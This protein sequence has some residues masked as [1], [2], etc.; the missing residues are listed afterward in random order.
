MDTFGDARGQ[1]TQ[2]GAVLLFAIAIIALSIY[3]ASVIPAQNEAAEFEHSQQVREDLLTVHNAIIAATD[4]G[5]RSVLV[6]LGLRYT[7]RL[8]GVNPGPVS[9]TIRTL[10]GAPWNGSIVID[11]ATATGETGDYWTGTPRRF[12]TSA[13]AYRARYHE[14]EGAG[15]L[16]TENTVFYQQFDDRKLLATGQHLVDGRRIGLVSLTG[17]LQQSGTRAQSISIR[18]LSADET[19]VPVRSSGGPITITVPTRLSA[20]TWR[21]MLDEDGELAADG[22]YVVGVTPG[23]RPETV[24]I[25]LAA[26]ETYLIDSSLVAVGS[27]GHRPTAA[28]LTSDDAPIVPEGGTARIEMT[29]RD[30]YD[31]GI[32]GVTVRVATARS[33]SSV[34]PQ[35]AISGA[36]GT[37]TVTYTAPDEVTGVEATDRVVAS[38]DV[39]PASGVDGTT[40]RNVSIPVIVQSRGSGGSGGSTTETYPTAFDD[41]DGTAEPSEDSALPP[42]DPVGDLANFARLATDGESATLSEAATGRG[43]S[44]QYDLRVGIETD[45]LDPGTHRVR[46][47][48]SY[49]RGSNAEPIGLT[50]VRSDG[51]EISGTRY[52]LPVADGTRTETIDLEPATNGAINSSGRLILRIDDSDGQGDRTLDRVTID[53]LV[54]LTE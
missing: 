53:R 40:A 37:M 15:R 46:V 14:H 18:A 33:D 22:G 39:D 41:G 54:V 7:P 52:D 30:A 20:A 21:S 25:E 38:L 43:A 31:T 28:Y 3:Q 27:V 50:A 8:V 23:D 24:R 11:N 13:I 44:R 12:E 16:V 2:I 48:Y 42:D 35:T 19:A 34:A 9:G 45:G 1:S 47:T 51:T 10:D 5:G 26:G 36:D 32:A 6:A 4:G 49:D 29:V 17:S